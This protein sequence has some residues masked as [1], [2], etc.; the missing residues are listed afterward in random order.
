M[1]HPQ[2]ESFLAPGA[3]APEL[4]DL[5]ISVGRNGSYGAISLSGGIDP[6]VLIRT[7]FIPG[8]TADLAIR[9]YT[10]PTTG[11]HPGMLYIHGGGWAYFSIDFYDAQLSALSKLTDS[12]IVSVNY[13]KAQEHKFP[14]PHDDSYIGLKWLFENSDSL[15]IDKK[16]IGI[17][18]D[19]AGANL[20]AGVA[21]RARDEKVFPLAYQL[22]IYP[23]LGVDFNTESY[24]KN[25]T[26]FGLTKR[27]MSW[28]WSLYL[29]RPEDWEN[30]YAVPL[31]SVD[32]Q[33]L[34]PTIVITAEYDVLRD[35]GITYANRLLEKGVSVIHKDFDGMI[36]GFF[37]YGTQ[38]DEGF[39]LRNWISSSINN[40]LAK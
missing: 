20:A 17:G 1:L 33:G 3:D 2:C 16:R 32:L 36:H 9:I 40:L 27:T 12:V 23:A 25:G 38:I 11:P 34:P 18:G 7:Q 21:L 31:S 29:D 28:L 26:G 22:L 10:P 5:P 4:I 35:D 19:S 8:V 14:I 24:V 13:Q 39:L 37:N 15:S 6:D 30:P